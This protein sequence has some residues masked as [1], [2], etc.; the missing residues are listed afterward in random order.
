MKGDE[1]SFVAK[2]NLL[3]V[4]F[5]KTYI[6]KHKKEQMIYACSNRMRELS[7]LLICYRK[8]VN[9]ISV[10]L[11]E[12]LIPKNFDNVLSATRT[13][14]GYDPIKKTFKSPSLAMH[15]GTSLKVTCD[16]LTHLIIKESSGFQTTSEAQKVYWL[17]N[18]KHFKK[19]IESRWNSELA[20]L[21]NKDLQDKR[22][23]KPLLLPLV[24]D[25]KVFREECLKFADNCSVLLKEQKDDVSTYK[26]LTNCILA[27]LI[28]FNRRRIGDVQFLK[29]NDYK[30]DQRTKCTDFDSVL[31]ET[32]KV[33]TTKYKR[34]LNS[35]KGSRAVVILVPEL[36]QTYI[37][38]L[39]KNRHKY[40]SPENEYVFAIPGSSIAWGKG[41]VAIRTLAKKVGLENYHALTSN[42]LRKHIATVMQ[43]LNLSKDET[44][45]FSQFMGHTEKTHQEFYE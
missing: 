23:N 42:K 4:Q 32:E 2:T 21:A 34:V 7:R 12:M 31:T 43:I 9:D 6:K 30:K 10:S 45:Q 22:W 20:S 38:L 13:I 14:V 15:L 39:L 27:L 25:I 3:I 40:I 37:E 35:G 18:I 11:K 36:L 17:K 29:I 28:V 33:L 24:N 8:Q 1:I 26:L 5:G 19:L 44:K 41:D 16:E